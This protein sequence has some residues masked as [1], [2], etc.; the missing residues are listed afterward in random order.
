[1]NIGIIIP[2]YEEEE[3]ISILVQEIKSYLKAKIIIIDDS[4]TN[5]TK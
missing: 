3:N 5:L 4:K 1:M 2:A